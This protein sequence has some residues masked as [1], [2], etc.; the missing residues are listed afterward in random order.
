SRFGSRLSRAAEGAP[1]PRGPAARFAA[2]DEANRGPG[3]HLGRLPEAGG[4]SVLLY[5]L[6]AIHRQQLS[7]SASSTSSEPSGRS[8]V[9]LV[10]ELLHGQTEWGE[11]I[12]VVGDCEGLGAWRPESG[13][14]L[15]TDPGSYPLWRGS[16]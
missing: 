13:A 8:V 10:F 7:S 15:A 16:Q 9:T 3:G 2:A 12:G 11:S 5:G 1:R 4:R 6:R 14:Y